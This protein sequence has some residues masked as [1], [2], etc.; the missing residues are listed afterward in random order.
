MITFDDTHLLTLGDVSR[1]HARRFASRLAVVCG[2]DRLTYAE[3]DERVSRAANVLRTNGC[4]RGSMVAWVG[5]NCHRA[6]ELVLAC[7]K[8]G[9]ALCPVNWRMSPAEMRFVLDDLEP[10]VVFWQETEIG[11]TVAAVRSQGP[12]DARR[13]GPIWIR[14]DTDDTEGYE[15]LLKQASSDDPVERIDPF[16]PVLV[17]Y[18]G[19]FA[20]RPHPTGLHHVSLT[21]RALCEALWN[22]ID[23]DSVYLNN[24][25]MFHV[26]N[27]RT[28][29][30]TYLLGG[31]NVFLRRVDATRMCELVEAER[32]TGAYLVPVTREQ[33]ASVNCDGRFDLSSLRDSGGDEVWRGMVDHVPGHSG[34]GQTETGG[35]VSTS[36]FGPPGIGNAGRSLPV[37]QV[38]V[39][40]RDGREC[41]AGGMGEIVARGP[42]VANGYLRRADESSR[43]FRD[44]WWHTGDLGRLE[45]DGTL[46]FV[47]P[48]GRMI[49]SASE[50]IYPAEV[51]ECIRRHPAV[52]A[53][54]VIGVP[55]PEW[56]QSVKAVVVLKEG[57]TLDGH[58]LIEHCRAHIAGYKKP[59]F[60]DVRDA[61]PM[62]GGAID[63]DALDREHGGGGYPGAELAHT[64]Q[65]RAS[66]PNATEIPR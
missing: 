62:A 1:E 56:T 52:A 41:P 50:N 33:M 32:C 64:D 24:G 57:Q 59:R 7:A 58:D 40:D 48:V 45:E 19:A 28:M 65:R 25:P 39:V 5:Q 13:G 31:R 17:I 47:G 54:A 12:R 55:D 37:A 46:T 18:T 27:W 3:L 30:P 2:E 49:K 11:A 34:Y 36:A 14:H 9:A 66:R 51:E 35:V 4:G 60:V 43:A 61:L 8:L 42:V 22:R 16:S 15:A 23:H 26:G 63:Y 21:V 20:G 29:M 38:R 44:G 53:V 6:F 10:Q